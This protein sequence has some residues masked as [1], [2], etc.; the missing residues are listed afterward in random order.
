MAARRT[1][2]TLYRS[3]LRA[4]RTVDKCDEKKL[5]F[6]PAKPSNSALEHYQLEGAIRRKWESYGFGE[7]YAA[8]EP[9]KTLIS[10]NSIGN[11]DF[12]DGIYLYGSDIRNLARKQFKS[13]CK[14]DKDLDDRIDLAFKVLSTLPLIMKQSARTSSHVTTKSDRI[15]LRITLTTFLESQLSSTAEANYSYRVQVE[16]LGRS[17]VQLCGRHWVIL[18]S[19]LRED[20]VVA[21]FA[22]GVVGA[23]PIIAPAEGVQYT[24]QCFLSTE[25][26]VMEG[27]FL[28]SDLESE[29]LFEAP[30]AK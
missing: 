6:T 16:N 2:V 20:H 25:S 18:N 5:L 8:E 22:P 14:N 10:E 15:K 13:P 24:S 29:E 7:V 23:N 30:I 21:K 26:G 19:N 4:A 11:K 12:S 17:S 3:L 28:F 9:E 1:S 27:S